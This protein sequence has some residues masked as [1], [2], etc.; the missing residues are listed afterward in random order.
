[1]LIFSLTNFPCCLT[2]NTTNK[3][4]ILRFPFLSFQ[5]LTFRPFL[6]LLSLAKLLDS[7]MFYSIILVL[8]ISTFASVKTEQNITH[9]HQV[10]VPPLIRFDRSFLIV[11]LRC[12]SS[13]FQFPEYTRYEPSSTKMGSPK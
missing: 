1:M 3:K 9:F 5:L 4:Q 12:S 7:K 6:R 13:S 2:K 11:L 8:F 10:I